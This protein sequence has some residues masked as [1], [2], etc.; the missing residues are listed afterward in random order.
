[1]AVILGM[2]AAGAATDGIASKNYV[3]TQITGVNETL[4]AKVDTA[5]YNADKANFETTAHAAETY[6]TKGTTLAEYG[7]TNA[8][9]K[10][11]V[12]SKVA[13]VVAG[14]MEESLKAYAKA[15][16]MTTALAGKVDTTTY[17]ADKATFE[18]VTG[19]TDKYAAKNTET[20]ASGAASAAATNAV[21]IGD[22]DSLTVA[23]SARG[24]LVAA[25]NAVKQ[26]V[27]DDQTAW[28]GAT[29]DLVTRV[30]SVDTSILSINSTLN[31]S[32]NGLGAVKTLA[33]NAGTAASE[34][35]TAA[36]AAQA[37]AEEAATAAA[38]YDEMLSNPETGY[39]SIQGIAQQ[40]KEL[41]ESNSE[42]FADYTKTADLGDLA[43][44]APGACSDSANKCVLTFDGVSYEWEVVAR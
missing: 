24:S 43:K 27:D 13:S 3:D 5:T 41:S 33:T 16:D 22:L 25:I 18:T 10:G 11:E 36:A 20:V 28:T 40:A 7:I 30:N 42:K 44:A 4:G 15:E 35:A 19:A 29:N 9:T 1:M 39:R 12:D 17:A 21:A 32:E 8:Y 26:A 37:K 6:A 34:A 14:D 31:D 23:E 2:N 38:Q